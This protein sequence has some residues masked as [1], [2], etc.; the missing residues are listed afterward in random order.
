[1][2][3]SKFI[4]ENSDVETKICTIILRIQ[5]FNNLILHS[6][7]H[8]L[9]RFLLARSYFFIR[10]AFSAYLKFFNIHSVPEY[11]VP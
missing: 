2:H 8:L 11:L 4:L 9:I 6:F 7:A 3:L 10:R 1:M 5:I